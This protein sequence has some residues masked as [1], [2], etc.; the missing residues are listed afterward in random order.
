METDVKRTVILPG[1]SCDACLG[2][3][4]SA[5]PIRKRA[6]ER[7]IA[8]AEGL[9]RGALAGAFLGLRETQHTANDAS[10]CFFGFVELREGA[11]NAEPLRIARVNA[12]NKG[13]NETIEKLRREFSAN[14][15]GDGFIAIRRDGFAEDVAQEGPFGL[16][17]DE[18]AGEKSGRAQGH[19][20]ERA[21]D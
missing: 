11:A 2:A 20:V 14:E 1:D 9:Q 16:R 8:F 3:E 5:K 10:G 4:R 19:R 18:R 15:G 17:V 6:H 13:G 12:G 21:V 7:F